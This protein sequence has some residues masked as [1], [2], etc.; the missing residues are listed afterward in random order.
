MSSSASKYFSCRHD[1]RAKVQYNSDNK[2]SKYTK[3]RIARNDFITNL[4]SD[5]YECNICG[6]TDHVCKVCKAV[7]SGMTSYNIIGCLQAHI[8]V[9]HWVRSGMRYKNLKYLLIPI[10]SGK[11]MINVTKIMKHWPQ[12]VCTL[13]QFG[14][15]T[16]DKIILQTELEFG[17]VITTKM[18]KKRTPEFKRIV[19]LLLECKYICVMCGMEY[20]CGMPTYEIFLN[21]SALCCGA[22]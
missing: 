19:E 17:H 3:E 22:R 4:L 21:H 16:I 13:R 15:K 20:E 2:Y 12:M 11:L 18:L 5:T 14:K 9:G 6:R 10:G 7:I 8:M 1:D